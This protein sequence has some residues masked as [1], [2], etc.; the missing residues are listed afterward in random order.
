MYP[1]CGNFNLSSLTASQ[2]S[3]AINYIAWLEL[4][5]GAAGGAAPLFWQKHKNT[6][7]PVIFL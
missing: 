1:Y 7:E 4:H 2:Y 6:G 3:A 5:S